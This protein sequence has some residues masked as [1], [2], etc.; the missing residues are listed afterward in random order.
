[1]TEEKKEEI[2]VIEITEEY[3]KNRLYEF[4]GKKVM[5][6]SDLAE[7]YGYETKNFKRQVKNNIAKFE[8]DD[9]MFEL[10]DEEV[11]NLSRCKNFTL[12]MGRGSNIKY[13]Y[14]EFQ[15]MEIVGEYSD[16]GHSGKNIK[17][18]QEFM[19]MLNDIEDGKDGVDFVLVF[20]LSRFG[21]NA[22]DVLS[23]LLLMQDYGVNLIC[24]A[25]YLNNQGYTKKLR[26]NG[27]IPGFSTS[28]IKKIIDNLVYMGKIGPNSVRRS[29]M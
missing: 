19:R 4:R 26:Q 16:E 28:F 10:N 3:M 22:A 14:A 8:G 5:L 20:K 21:R 24:V 12:N 15:D 13:K 2:A 6:D 1:M 18:R 17:G 7:I 23:S 27:T 25:N 29:I 11:E 9:F